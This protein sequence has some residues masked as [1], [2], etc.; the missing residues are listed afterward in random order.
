[1]Q[2]KDHVV[3]VQIDPAIKKEADAVLATMGL[4]ASDLCRMAITWV[5]REKR[6]PCS[7]DIHTSDI[8]NALTRETLEKADRGE[9]LV[10]ARD[11]ED[12]FRKLGI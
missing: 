1:M 11:A 4:T 5:A 3:F 2:E 10:R 12:L 9:E 6:L 7:I 8:P